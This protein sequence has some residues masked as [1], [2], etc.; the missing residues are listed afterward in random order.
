[1]PC[2][3]CI[4]S[5]K[6]SRLQV[7]LSAAWRFGLGALVG[8]C[9]WRRWR[10][11]VMTV[12]QTSQ[13][14]FRRKPFWKWIMST[15]A[16]NYIGHFVFR[17][18]IMKIEHLFLDTGKRQKQLVGAGLHRASIFCTLLGLFDHCVVPHPNLF[19]TPIAHVWELKNNLSISC[20]PSCDALFS[21]V[22][23]CFASSKFQIT[24]LSLRCFPE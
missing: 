16:W 10:L 6:L 20:Q 23:V 14:L 22:K 18:E 13:R 15:V 8:N 21:Y 11:G 7:F 24:L 4:R 17:L 9:F 5:I 19:H 1:M 3:N 2:K 12:E